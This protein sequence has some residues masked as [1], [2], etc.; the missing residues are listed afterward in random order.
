MSER[1]QTDR[2]TLDF[3]YNHAILI[4]FFIH[5]PTYQLNNEKKLVQVYSLEMAKTNMHY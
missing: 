5:R 1:K 4:F 3:R 2:P